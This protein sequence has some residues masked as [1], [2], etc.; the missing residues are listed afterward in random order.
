MKSVDLKKKY[1]EFFKRNGHRE[2]TNASLIPENDPTVLFTTAGM[3]P[4]VPFLLGEKHPAGRRL[5][6]VQKCVRTGDIEEVGDNFHLTFFEMLGNWSLGDYF[7]EEAIKMSYDFLI[8]E[9][10]LNKERIG[11]TCFIG[12]KDAEK[13]LVSANVWEKLG[14]PKERIFFLDKEDNWW[15]PAGATGPCGPD[16]EMFY[17]VGR[18]IPDKFNPKDGDWI[19]IWNNVFMEYNKK[20]RFLLVDGMHCLYDKDFK[21]NKKLVEILQKVDAKKIL[22]INGY[23]EKAEE[24][25]KNYNYEIFS[26]DGKIMKN[27]KKF[28]EKLMEKYKFEKEDALY[29]DHDEASLETAEEFGIKNTMLYDGKIKKVEDFIKDNIVYYDRLK[30]KNVDTGM[31]VERT[32]A[33]L[34]G[35]SDIYQIDSLKPLMDA[36]SNI[37]KKNDVR[38]KRIIVDHLRAATFILNEGVVPSNIERGYVLRR[39]IRRAIRHG[40]LLGIQQKFCNEIVKEVFVSYKWNH[41]FREE[42]ILNEIAKEEE[43]FDISLSNG[44]QVFEKEIKKLKKKILPG[45][46]AFLL[47]TS[48]G[49]P[50]EMIQEL[51]KEKKLKVDIGGY[52]KEFEKHKELSRTA[53]EGKFKSG[54]ADHSSETTRLHT[55]THLLLQALK[56]VLKDD[57]LMQKGSNITAERMRFDFNFSRKLTDDEIKKI[58]NEVNE[59]IKKSLPVHF[60]EMKLTEAKKIGAIGVFEHKY[61]DKVK[62][63]FIG[64]YSKELCSGPHVSNTKEIGKFKIVKEES[65]SAGVRRIKA[66]LK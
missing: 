11:V 51:A 29:F 38:S 21:L 23:K 27:N 45:R 41:F 58:E 9:L 44:M 25:L 59:Q 35:L 16:T 37:S 30:Q 40:K 3:H 2:I 32:I 15:G 24:L 20:R 53:A 4:L 47:F 33:A 26:L 54:L 63:Y 10:G 14:V 6:N 50:L 65:S 19:E 22:I 8:N 66:V 13:D 7:K 60:E 18:K 34:D 5:V 52:N 56:E 49:F 57:N 55:A 42:F 28:F 36:V 64:K 31:G 39:L 1:I 46:V 12:D 17:Y 48:Y 62:V 61:G 43:K